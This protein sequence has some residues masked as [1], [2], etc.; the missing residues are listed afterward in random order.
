LKRKLGNLKSPYVFQESGIQKILSAPLRRHGLA[1]DTGLG[2]SGTALAACRRAFA[3]REPN[4]RGLVVTPAVVRDHWLDEIG[5]WWP[6][7]P[8]AAAITLGKERKSGVS[9]K[10]AERRDQAYKSPIQVAS[11]SLLKHIDR[12]GWDFIILDE[13][14]RLKT[15]NSAQSLEVRE[16]VSENPEAMVVPLTATPMPDDVCDIWNPCDITWPGR[17]GTTTSLR[18]VSWQFANRYSVWRETIGQDGTVYGGKFSGLNPTHADELRFRL[19]Q[20]WHRVTKASVAHLL[21]PFMVQLL[22]VEPERQPKFRDVD[23]WLARQGEEKFPSVKEWLEDAVDTDT[24][25]CVLTHLTETVDRIG[26][27]A[28]RFGIPVFRVSGSHQP[29]AEARNRV[30][31][32]AKAAPKS[33][34]VATMHSV[35]IGIDLTFATRALFAELYWRPETVLQALGRFSR[36]SGIL[37]SSVTILCLKGTQ[38]EAIARTIMRKVADISKAI[39]AG[40]GESRLLEVLEGLRMTDAEAIDSINKAL[41]SE[42][43]LAVF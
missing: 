23:D 36:L 5:E 35:G 24:H 4:T 6:E 20:C 31:A 19:D 2:K 39:G 28:A 25:V 12:R 15:P 41:F 27:Y 7:H 14:H 40:D 16:I 9:K 11:Y 34:V 26:S 1:M 33:I 3:G 13:A 22:K 30:L 10:A 17:F 21:P 32:E 38:D 8:S 42:D 18:Y 43:F 37:P 29:T